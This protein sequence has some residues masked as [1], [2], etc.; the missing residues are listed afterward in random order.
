MGRFVLYHPVTVT[1]TSSSLRNSKLL[2]KPVC[3]LQCSQERVTCWNLSWNSMTPLHTLTTIS[4][5]LRN[6]YLSSGSSTEVFYVC[7]TFPHDVLHIVL[8][9]SICLTTL[10]EGSKLQPI[11]MKPSIHGHMLRKFCKQK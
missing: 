4:A 3:S 9:Y 2:I 1:V 7:I 10:G 11:N 5:N 8:L 6:Y